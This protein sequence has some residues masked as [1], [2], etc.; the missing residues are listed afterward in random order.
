[1][2]VPSRQVWPAGQHVGFASPAD[3]QVRSLLQQV[4]SGSSLSP[5]GQQMKVMVFMSN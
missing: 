1:M 5:C 4:P 3:W 2:H